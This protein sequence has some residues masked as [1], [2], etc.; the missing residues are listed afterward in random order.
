[1]FSNCNSLTNLNLS[2]FNTQNITDIYSMFF[3]CNSLTKESIITKDN[4]ILNEF[5][6][7]Y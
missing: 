6:N 3:G 1:M 4:K 5:E 2:N 7:K